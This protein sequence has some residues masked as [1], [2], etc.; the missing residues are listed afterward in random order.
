MK[1]NLKHYREQA[2][3][4]QQQMA[5]RLG[6]KYRTYGS[7][8]RGEVTFDVKQLC[9]CADILDCSTDA[10]LDRRIR[11]VFSDPRQE[12]LNQY[13][14]TCDESRRNRIVE[15]ARDSMIAQSRELTG[16]SAS[17]G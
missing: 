8:E 4:S 12:E 14:E 16:L 7:W 9:C 6:V 11:T 1:T 17:D 15:I 2:G 3:L 5:D 10:I 13:W